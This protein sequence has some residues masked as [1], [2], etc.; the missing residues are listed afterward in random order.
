VEE[1]QVF[2]PGKIHDEKFFKY[3]KE[4]LRAS[5]WVLSTIQNGYK[6]PF[7]KLPERY[8]ERNNASARAEPSVVQELVEEMITLK[9]VKVVDKKPNC[10]SPLGLVTK[11]AKGKKK[12]RLVFDASRCV[13]KCLDTPPVK[14]TGLDKA[15]EIRY[16]V[17]L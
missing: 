10:V 8:E 13:N 6:L 14:L 15:L 2:T 17:N 7:L 5:P 16:S 1:L 12:Y 11:L 3:W 9:V 4:E